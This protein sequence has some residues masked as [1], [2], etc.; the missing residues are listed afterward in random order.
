MESELNFFHNGHYKPTIKESFLKFHAEN[1]HIY[2][3]FKAQVFLAIG[4]GHKKF[5]AKMIIEWI[6]WETFTKTKGNEFKL[7]NNFAPLYPRMFV[8]DYP[9]Y[10]DLFEFRKLRAR[11]YKPEHGDTLEPV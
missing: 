6:R 1:P 11:G 4:K 10:G 5:A 9:Q 3:M 2:E 8:Q 7:N